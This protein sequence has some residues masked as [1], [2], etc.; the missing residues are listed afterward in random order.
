M[1]WHLGR[2]WGPSAWNWDTTGLD[3]GNYTIHAWTNQSGA[4]QATYE[5]IGSAPVTLTGC[6]AATVTPSNTS[7]NV[8][9]AVLFTVAPVTCSGTPVFEYWVQYPDGTWHLGMTF[10]T[11]NTWN[12]V[13]TNLAK[14]TYVIHVWVNNQGADTSTH[15]TIAA[16]NH[17]LT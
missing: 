15:E 5:A 8:G 6:T 9:T 1:S 7:S 14:G 2:T 11:S 13:T 10:T 17:T 3:P 12:W 4:S 16:T